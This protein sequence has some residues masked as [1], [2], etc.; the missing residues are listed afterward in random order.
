M[1]NKA[2]ILVDFEKEWTNPDSDY[3][4]GD[5]TNIIKKVNKLISYCRKNDYKI[6][7]TTHI[8]KNSD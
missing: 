2:L 4:V 7:F 6:I 8:E 1:T 3:Y 5:I